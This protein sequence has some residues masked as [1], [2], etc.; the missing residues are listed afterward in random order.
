MKFD[1][2]K[3]NEEK[4]EQDFWTINRSKYKW[5]SNYVRLKIFKKWCLSVKNKGAFLDV[6]GGVGNWAFH[7]LDYFEK[8]IVLDISKKALE[9]IPEKEI[10]KKQGSADKIPLKSKTVDCILLADV[11][12]HI[13]PSDLNK[14]MKELKRVLKDNGRIVIQTSLY[15][16]G[17]GLVFKRVFKKMNG[18]LMKSEMKEGHLNRLKFNEI[19]SLAKKNGLIIEDYLFYSIIF[20]QLT[21]FIKDLTAKAMSKESKHI[22]KGQELKDRLKKVEKPSKVFRM[23]FGTFSRI[24]YLDIILFG[25]IL[26]GQGIFLKLRKN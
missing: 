3:Y 8:V 10:I 18:R 7:F 14:V 5:F 22:R 4:Y 19:K 26:P 2:K 23:I 17:I 15:G 16:Y 11:L 6:G 24:S 21:D 25:K 20:Q 9:K 1:Y 12:E 13:H